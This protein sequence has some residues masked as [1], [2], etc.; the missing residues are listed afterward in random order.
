MNTWVR[1]RDAC[2]RHAAVE[3]SIGFT[4]VELRVASNRKYAAF[5]LVELLVVIAI[6][7]I[8]V[9]LLLPAIQSSRE[10]A[11]RAHCQNNVKQM[12]LA[13]ANH[14]AAR[15]HFPTGGWGFKWVGEP[16]DGYSEHQPGGWAY[17]I[18]SYLEQ[19]QLRHLG[20]GLPSRFTDPMNPER[21]VALMKLVATPLPVFNCPSKRPLG[22]W[23]Y[24]H[25]PFNPFMAVNLFSCTY[26]NSCR[27]MR[28]DYRVNSGSK[29]AGGETGP[30]LTQDPKTFPWAFATANAQNGICYQRSTVRTAQI[31]DGTSKT[32]MVGEKFL[33]PDRYLDGV[34]PSDDQCVFTGHDR[35]N[36]GYTRHGIE[37][38]RPLRD[39]RIGSTLPFRFGGPH[40]A[41]LNMAFCDG[42][43]EHIS[44]DI[45]DDV[46]GSF[47]GRN[48]EQIGGR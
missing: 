39:E 15:G 29:N 14:E 24:A 44:F 28:S 42:S 20:S 22:T 16:N 3:I 17:N 38:F 1:G 36:A 31:T 46:W 48:D 27:V 18:L 47:G 2:S 25:D 34:D 40:P 13:F 37:V 35:D 45:N 21:Q 6:I 7:G 11:R 26:D 23:P 19:E 4:L 10:T 41:G 5:T 12:A 30:G 32:A 43:V 33:N 8:L 9:A